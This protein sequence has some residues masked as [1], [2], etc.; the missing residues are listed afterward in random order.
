MTRKRFVK[1]LMARDYSRNEAKEEATLVQW[2]REAYTD[3]Y[4]I[5]SIDRTPM[6]MDEFMEGCFAVEVLERMGYVPRRTMQIRTFD[7]D[8]NEITQ[9]G[10]SEMTQREKLIEILSKRIS[11]SAD[12]LDGSIDGVSYKEILADFLIE[13][14]VV[15]VPCKAGDTIYRVVTMEGTAHKPFIHV[16]KV[17]FVGATVTSPFGGLSPLAME[18]YGKEWFMDKA[19]AEAALEKLLDK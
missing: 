18:D 16:D 17:S 5:L 11:R 12:I 1:L 14:G 2:N 8:G 10:D 4:D 13:N 15:A 3:I 7:S 6:T 9:N 19:E